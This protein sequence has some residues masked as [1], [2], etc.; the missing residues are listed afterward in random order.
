MCSDDV[1]VN[2]P[3]DGEASQH[4]CQASL[5]GGRTWLPSGKVLAPFDNQGY[6]L[7]LIVVPTNRMR[8]ALDEV[9]LIS[10]VIE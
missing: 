2:S 6:P 10:S 5:P 4:R 3:R 1:T 9:E 8:L 7:S